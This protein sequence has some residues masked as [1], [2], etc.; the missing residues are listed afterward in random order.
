MSSFLIDQWSVHK[1]LKNHW[2]LGM[3]TEMV[4]QMVIE[5]SNTV[6]FKEILLSSTFVKSFDMLPKQKKLSFVLNLQ[7][8]NENG[9]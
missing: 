5:K 1:S 7:I 3:A 6:P 4:T 8:S 9:H 2:S